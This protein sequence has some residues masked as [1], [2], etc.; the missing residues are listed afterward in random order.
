MSDVSLFQ[1]GSVTGLTED[2]RVLR[3]TALGVV[4]ALLA[5]F[6]TPGW[7][8]SPVLPC[9][10]SGWRARR[11]VRMPRCPGRTLRRQRQPRRLTPM[12]W[13]S[14]PPTI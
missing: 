13:W 2:L 1:V 3:A 8:R 5:F 10:I 11:P 9:L 14:G 12:R 6:A 4:V 7:P